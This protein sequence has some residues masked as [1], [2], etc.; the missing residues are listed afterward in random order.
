MNHRSVL[1]LLVALVVLVGPACATKEYLYMESALVPSP[2]PGGLRAETVPTGYMEIAAGGDPLACVITRD[3]DPVFEVPAL[4]LPRLQ[5]RA[6]LRWGMTSFLDIGLRWTL[7]G[8]LTAAPN[9][10]WIVPID[11]GSN[12]LGMAS[13]LSGR[14]GHPRK[15]MLRLG[16]EFGFVAAPTVIYTCPACTS[17]SWYDEDDDGYEDAD[18]IEWSTRAALPGDALHPVKSA[19]VV[20]PF[21][22]FS[23]GAAHRVGPVG[24]IGGVTFRTHYVNVGMYRSSETDPDPD[25]DADLEHPYVVPYVGV[26]IHATEDLIVQLQ[27][28]VPFDTAVGA[29]HDWFRPGVS[30]MLHYQFDLAGEGT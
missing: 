23:V 17:Y 7:G 21:F 12:V 14:I 9:R 25:L 11:D 10:D 18:E 20:R 5:A 28:Y 26:D 15:L 8:E 29:G 27:G 24:L 1:L 22:L 13:T 3:E 4:W 19:V 2:S 30:L 16:M 6:D